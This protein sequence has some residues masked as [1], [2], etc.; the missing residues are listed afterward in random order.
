MPRG[1]IRTALLPM[2]ALIRRDLLRYLRRVRVFVAIAA[3]AAYLTWHFAASWPSDRISLEGAVDFVTYFTEAMYWMFQGVC[4]LVI[5]GFAALA[6]RSERDN[7]TYELMALTLLTPL[8]ILLGTI[9]NVIGLFVIAVVAVL[10]MFLLPNL[11]SISTWYVVPVLLCEI[12]ATVAATASIGVFAS[13]FSRKASNAVMAAYAI[14][15]IVQMFALIIGLFVI[16]VIVGNYSAIGSSTVADSLSIIASQ[17]GVFVIF[18]WCSLRVLEGYDFERAALGVRPDTKA[19]RFAGTYSDI[20]RIEKSEGISVNAYSESRD[21]WQNTRRQEYPD[22]RNPVFVREFNDALRRAQVDRASISFAVIFVIV[23]FIATIAYMLAYSNAG[24]NQVEGIGDALS[25]YFMAQ[26]ALAGFL[27]PGISTPT[28]TS[29]RNTDMEDS[30]RLTLITRRELV[31]GRASGAIALPA[32]VLACCMIATSP[33]LVVTYLHPNGFLMVLLGFTAVLAT[34]LVLL[35]I[36][37]RVARLPLSDVA[38]VA[39]GYA[40]TLVYFFLPNVITS[41]FHFQLPVRQFITAMSPI[42]VYSGV[43]SNAGDFGLVVQ[44]I[45]FICW[46][47]AILAGLLGSD[48]LG[49]RRFRFGSARPH[50]DSY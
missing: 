23:G 8:S 38:A 30:L 32:I 40:L 6:I 3:F 11:V 29:E 13:V 31:W 20:E 10:P 17:F 4:L 27:I 42:T 45:L 28:W 15:I 50:L 35:A 14:T 9:A 21:K 44:W 2:S 7:D 34:L 25:W 49:E 36:S 1:G 41:W 43:G 26:I 24:K 5:P 33:I 18:A 19:I 47:G 37:R 12:L 46:Q 39:L 22:G 16:E 48:L